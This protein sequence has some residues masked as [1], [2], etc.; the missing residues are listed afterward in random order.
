MT[1]WSAAETAS[2]AELPVTAF[3]ASVAV[4]VWEP[5][6]SNAAVRV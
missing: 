3:A 1:R 5:A 6:V 4:I 2:A